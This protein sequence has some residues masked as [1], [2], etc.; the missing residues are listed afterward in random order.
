MGLGALGDEDGGGCGGFEGLVDGVASFYLG[1]GRA[2]GVVWG[3][4]VLMGV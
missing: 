3:L 2:H 1:G 4:R